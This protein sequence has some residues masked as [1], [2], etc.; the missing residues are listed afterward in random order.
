MEDCSCRNSVLYVLLA[1]E[2]NGVGQCDVCGLGMS[3]RGDFF[4][5]VR[6]LILLFN[7]LMVAWKSTNKLLVNQIA[8]IDPPALPEIVPIG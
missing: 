4:V 3:N 2:E 8:S 5:V 7:M 1:Y 6:I